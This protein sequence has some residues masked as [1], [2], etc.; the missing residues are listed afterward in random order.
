MNADR[1]KDK[2]HRAMSYLRLSAFIW[3]FLFFICGCRVPRKDLPPGYYSGPTRTMA[4]VVGAVN[5]NNRKLPTLWMRHNLRAIIVDPNKAGDK[6]TKVSGDG[7]IIYR[8][9]KELFFR[10]SAPGTDLFEL[11]CNPDEYWLS[12]PFSKVDQM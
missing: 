11:G 9:P 6:G 3:G 2:M 8:S 10:A 1:T 4:E 5:E 12:I 7:H